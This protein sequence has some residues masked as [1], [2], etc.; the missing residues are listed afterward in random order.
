MTPAHPPAGYRHAVDALTTLSRVPRRPPRSD[1]ALTAL[2]LVWAVIEAMVA[3]GPGAL[4]QRLAFAVAVTV[5]LVMRRRVPAAVLAVLI[6]A[7]MIRVAAIPGQ[8][9]STFPFPSLLVATFSVALHARRTGTAVAGGVATLLTLLS[10][11]PLGY[12]AGPPTVGQIF[13]L[14]FFVTGA[15]VAGWLVRLRVAQA[16]SARRDAD[17]VAVDAE[18]RAAD[19][20]AAERARISRE[21]HDVVAHSL[22]IVAV[23]AG[24]AEELITL[25]PG[26]ARRHIAAARRT[27]REALTEM[28]HVLDVQRDA[29]AGPVLVPQPTL[30][31]VSD[32]V[33]EVRAAGLPVTLTAE[34]ARG[35]VPAG[36][37]L[38]GFRIVQ[39]AL[40]NVRRHAG[41][42]ETVVRICYTDRWIDIEVR[43]AA[44]PRPAQVTAGGGRGLVGMRERSRLY[45]GSVTAGPEGDGFTVRARLPRESQ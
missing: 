9:E 1:V 22:S 25:D 42:V 19:A 28:R 40:T 17:R 16:D 4:W 30:E 37:D 10:L 11:Y 13:I 26:S 14:G 38:A 36:V 44:G 5:P 41:P 20:V 39:E 8:E 3:V 32:L 45:G 43:N 15:W 2:L 12:Y 33:D 29:D 18:R 35:S 27:A 21:L 31:R 34:G 24:A 23:Q 6:G 7:L